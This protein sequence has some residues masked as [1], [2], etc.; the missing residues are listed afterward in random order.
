MRSLFCR[1]SNYWN[2]HG[3]LLPK[4]IL[5]V[6]ISTAFAQA[7]ITL[8][9]LFRD[10]AVLQRD[11]P[12]TIWGW[13]AP[14]RTITVSFAGKKAEAVA[15]ADGK[16]SMKMGPFPA[17]SQP[18]DLTAEGDGTVSIHDVLIGEVW[19]CSGQ[20]NMVWQVAKAKEGAK[21]CAAAKW[22]LIRHF[23]TTRTVSASPLEKVEGEWQLCTP[24]NTRLFTAVGYFF[25][26]DLFQSL[27]VPVGIINSSWGG[28]PI[29]SWMSA[30]S[31][32]TDPDFASVA[33]H[34]KQILANYPSEKTRYETALAEWTRQEAAAKASGTPFAKSKPRAPGG[35]GSSQEPSSLYNAMIHP[36]IP[37]TLRGILWYQ[38]E[39]NSG[40][41]REYRKLFPALITSWREDF[42]NP[43]LP[44]Y[45]MQLANFKQSRDETGVTWAYLREAQSL[46]LKL[47]Q[48]AQ[49]VTI[50]IGESESIHPLNKQEVG[51]R[52]ALVAKS[53]LFGGGQE[54]SGPVY[55]KATVEKGAMRVEFSH[56]DGGLV[57][58]AEPLGAFLV[59]GADKVFQPA[60]AK[61]DGSTVVV[62]SDLVKE[63]VAVR[64]AWSNDPVARLANKSGLPASPFRS[65]SW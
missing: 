39:N 7:E 4:L 27:N 40:R 43:E 58:T 9:S 13:S 36:F 10:H 35:P 14:G 1:A 51:R 38:G 18:Q 63:P 30:R 49:V 65:D 15:G 54:Y 24:E 46:A 55:V 57:A 16:W 22:P 12:L 28:T 45:W 50:D 52:L 61:I 44:F 11:L 5:A 56:A 32:T 17:S 8:G 21:E 20:S 48:T 23:L 33:E 3:R 25:A 53:Q 42:G 29:E 19:L 60:T 6:W 26:R 31:F 34:W 41:S 2:F 64:Y 47:P 62:Q 59:A 37:F